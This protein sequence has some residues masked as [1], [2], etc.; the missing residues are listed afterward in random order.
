MGL[1]AVWI[2]HRTENADAQI[3]VL[4]RWAAENPPKGA[5]PAK[6]GVCATCANDGVACG[7]CKHNPDVVDHF[8]RRKDAP[9]PPDDGTTA[10]SSCKYEDH[11]C[12]ETPCVDCVHNDG[13]DEHYD[14][15]QEPPKAARTYREDFDE[16]HPEAPRHAGGSPKVL[17]REVYKVHEAKMYEY[18]HTPICEYWDKPL[19]YWEKP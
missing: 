8:A 2:L 19:G 3:G 16:K 18:S 10:C 15:A 11:D 1:C 7:N 14:P 17:L 4:R 6:P 9:T 12:D 13:E 5:K